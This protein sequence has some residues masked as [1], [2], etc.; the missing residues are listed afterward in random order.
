MTR[1]DLVTLS[2]VYEELSTD[3][4]QKTTYIL[5][6]LWRDIS[7]EFDLIGPYFTSSNGLDSRFT[8]TCLYE[9]MQSMESVGFKV[10]ALVCDGASWNLSMV[11]R[12]CAESIPKPADEDVGSDVEEEPAA[13]SQSFC[14]N[15]F[16]D[17]KCF[18]INC[19]SHQV[20]IHFTYTIHA[21][22]FY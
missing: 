8:L 4:S 10:R 9:V 6:F 7:S 3:G 21:I 17:N 22:T 2:D 19:P 5:Q 14:M 20:C 15:P 18:I 12:L 13:W 11:K 16:S 1:D